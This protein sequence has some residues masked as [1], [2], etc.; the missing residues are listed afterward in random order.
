[1]VIKVGAAVVGFG[2][3]RPF[4]PA[5]T[6]ERTAEVTYFIMPEHTRQGLGTAMLDFFVEQAGRRGIDSLVASVSSRNHE[7]LK[8]QGKDGFRECGRLSQ[9]GRKFGQDVDVLWLQK[10]LQ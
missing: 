8:F 6:F 1:V 10:R 5:G 4:H 9:A 7:S 3:L 2:F